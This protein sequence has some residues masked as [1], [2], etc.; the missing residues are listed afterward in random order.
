MPAITSI[1][2][3]KNK[4]RVNVFLDGKFAFGIDLDNFV[5]LG[6][7]VDK[8]LSEKEIEEI[9]KKAEFKKTFDKLLKFASLRPRSRKEVLDWFD[10]KKVHES[11]QDELLKKLKDLGFLDDFS[12]AMWWVEQRIAFKKKSKR[13][14]VRELIQKGINKET[15]DT[16]MG[17]SGINEV[18]SIREILEKHSYKWER[19]GEREKRL[20][21]SGYLLRRGFGW[22][23][24]KE[25]LGEDE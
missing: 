18:K 9:V 22:D 12:F 20:K 13:E 11:I 24:I 21:I 16:V 15:I 19:F 3:Q 10:R 5:L 2:P 17:K 7:K 23:A 6:L 14:I 4:N 25:A 1:S 8:E